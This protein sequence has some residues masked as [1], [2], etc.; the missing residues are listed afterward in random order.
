MEDSIMNDKKNEELKEKPKTNMDKLKE[1]VEK[2]CKLRQYACQRLKVQE[3]WNKILEVY[4]SVFTALLAVAGTV[5]NGVFLTMPSAC[6][7][8]ASAIIVCFANAQNYARRA[9]DLEANIS[10]LLI[11]R[12]ELD[13]VS[14]EKYEKYVKNF[15][16][17][18]GD[19][20][21]PGLVDKCKC[22][23]KHKHKDNNKS[24]NNENETNN[25]ENK[26]LLRIWYYAY[27]IGYS[28]FIIVLFLLP[29][30]F[31]ILHFNDLAYVVGLGK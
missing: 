12:A 8:V 1:D 17:K 25:D 7:T 28:I 24:N 18:C 6:F 26:A 29:V 31:V 2:E 27:V 21:R 14:S 9:H 3:F 10:D 30:M 4:Y 22:K 13:E 5:E 20:E 16:K 23:E 11:F 19:S 15:Y